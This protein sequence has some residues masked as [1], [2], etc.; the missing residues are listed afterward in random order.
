M[1][2]IKDIMFI[3]ICQDLFLTC[4]KGIKGKHKNV[5]TPETITNPE[6]PNQPNNFAPAKFEQNDP[7]LT[8]AVNKANVVA[9]VPIGH[10]YAIMPSIKRCVNCPDTLKTML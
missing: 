3:L 7:K 10:I 9:S 6:Y 2:L 1:P 8:I 5:V 4:K